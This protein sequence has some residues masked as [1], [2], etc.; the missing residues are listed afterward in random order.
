MRVNNSH[1]AQIFYTGGMQEVGCGN[2]ICASLLSSACFS[3]LTSLFH[4]CSFYEI[5]SS[6]LG[7]SRTNFGWDKFLL[8]NEYL[9]SKIL[10]CESNSEYIS[11]HVI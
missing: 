5:K 4:L 10:S 1:I 7:C 3:L 11:L 6:S 2:D 8:L 9:E